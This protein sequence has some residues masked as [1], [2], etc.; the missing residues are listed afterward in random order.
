MVG[1]TILKR[2][3]RIFSSLLQIQ[4]DGLADPASQHRVDHD[5]GAPRMSTFTELV[6][7]GDVAEISEE[8]NYVHI[9]YLCK[10]IYIYMIY[11]ID[12]IDWRAWFFWESGMAERIH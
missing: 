8:E 9:L 2:K 11:Y 1:F 6:N 3:G 10:Y 12:S 5:L 4:M 7:H